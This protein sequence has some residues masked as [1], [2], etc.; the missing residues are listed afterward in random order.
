M[1]IKKVFEKVTEIRYTV[2]N[3]QFKKEN[4]YA[5][6]LCLQHVSSKIQVV[7]DGRV[8]DIQIQVSYLKKK[9]IF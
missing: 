2:Y 9:F 1:F 3:K 8:S 4:N 7:D 6:K 5:G